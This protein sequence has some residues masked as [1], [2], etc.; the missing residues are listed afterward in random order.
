MQFEVCYRPMR[1]MRA[2]KSQEA[3]K[4]EVVPTL[5]RHVRRFFGLF[6]I[7]VVRQAKRIGTTNRPLTPR[8][9]EMAY[10]T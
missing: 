10:F 9:T 1:S 6:Q 8:S 3:G 5:G 4:N 2:P 7:Y